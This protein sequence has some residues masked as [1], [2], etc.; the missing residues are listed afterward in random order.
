MNPLD[1]LLSAST[2]LATQLR[3]AGVLPST[4]INPAYGGRGISSLPSTYRGDEL[5]L[6]AKARAAQI[7]RGGSGAGGS[8]GG[9]NMGGYV[10]RGADLYS[11]QGPVDR[12]YRKAK[13]ETSAMVATDPMMQQWEAARQAKD[14]ATADQLGKQIW[15]NTY[16]GGSMGQP[17]GSI[18]STNPLMRSTFGYQTG[19]APGDIAQT[20]T[21]PAAIPVGPGEAPYQMGDLGTGALAE[22]GYD[23]TRYGVTPERIEEIKKQL[24]TQAGAK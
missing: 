11:S 16:G 21:N 1:L 8:I 6:A 23:T 3:K 2:G 4:G 5:Q 24:L 20:I 7:M 18:G 9:G 17:G 14:Y 13:A 12:A 19:M 10:P 22:T 15:Q